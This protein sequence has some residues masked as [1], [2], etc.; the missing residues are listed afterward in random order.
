MNPQV[1]ARRQARQSDLGF[2]GFNGT[3]NVTG[4]FKIDFSLG[5]QCETSRRAVDEPHT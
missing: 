2:R 1:S 4:A 5:G 3:E